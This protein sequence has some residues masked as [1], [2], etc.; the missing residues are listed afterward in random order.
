MSDSLPPNAE[1]V[2][3][4]RLRKYHSNFYYVEAGGVLYECAI[5]GLI[6]KEG[7][8]VLVGDFVE[9]DSVNPATRTA[10]IQRILERKNAISRPKLANVDQVL[11]VYSLMEPQ[12]D[13]HQMDRYL[14]HIELAGLTPALCISKADL[15]ATDADLEKIRAVYTERLG[16]QVF[17]TTVK[18][19]ESLD[20]VRA[21]AKG[22]IT[23]LAGPS[24]S[25]KSSL[26][27]AL[28]ADLQLRVGEVSEKI[29]RGQHTTRHVELLSLFE[30]SPDT[31]I[32]DTPGFSNL[33]FN[34]VLPVQLEAA[35]RDFAP[36][37]AQCSFSDC[38]HVDEE[39]CAVRENLDH[40]A[41]SRY[42]SYLDLLAEARLYKDEVNS[43]SQ[44]QEFGYK[45]LDRKGKDSVRIL[46]LKEKNRDASR[47]T[48]KQQVSL[49]HAEADD[50]EETGGNGLPV[51]DHPPESV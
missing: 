19:A 25:G 22:K 14:T 31:L 9:L 23:V 34:Y 5:R 24:G 39:G 42:R 18:N 12:F 4:G 51:E 44:K 10:R 37:R 3:T 1:S 15:A 11:V 36:Y 40:I 32:A 46:R 6:K 2:L 49:L 16:Y 8:D 35:F 50:S 30:D 21:L 33:K 20:A 41:E 7:G 28:N 27:N 43:T 26:L 38:L 29:A 45:Q 48:Q 17:F 47:R 13:P